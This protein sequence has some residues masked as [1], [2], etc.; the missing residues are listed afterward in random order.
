MGHLEQQK[1]MMLA[2][3]Q[4]IEHIFKWVFSRCW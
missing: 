1:R 3:Y 4:M 2:V